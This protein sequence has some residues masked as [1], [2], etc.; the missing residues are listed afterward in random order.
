MRCQ[1]NQSICKHQVNSTESKG[2][3][4]NI[5]NMFV[6]VHGVGG[7]L[8]ILWRWQLSWLNTP[9]LIL[10]MCNCIRFNDALPSSWID[11]NESLK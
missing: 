10:I 3:Y 5:I 9:Y 4:L 6:I 2:I 8:T 11:S 1:M 7:W